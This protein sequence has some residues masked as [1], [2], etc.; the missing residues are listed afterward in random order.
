[1]N[2]TTIDPHVYLHFTHD[3]E[4]HCLLAKQRN[5]VRVKAENNNADEIRTSMPSL[6]EAAMFVSDYSAAFSDSRAQVS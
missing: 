4:D 2:R 5:A 6:V 1:M 3:T